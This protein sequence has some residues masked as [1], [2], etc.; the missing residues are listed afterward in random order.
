L[1]HDAGPSLVHGDL[2]SGNIVDGRALIDPAVSFS[3]RE[4]DLAF[5]TVFG[6]IPSDFFAGY[7]EAWPLDPGWERRR[8]ALQLYHLLV[9]VELFGEGYVPMVTT[10][11]DQLGL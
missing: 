11:L 3:D 9:H 2:W 4:I 10:R 6:G 1:D 7:V 8:P 5:A